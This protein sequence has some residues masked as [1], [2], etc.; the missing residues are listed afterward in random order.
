VVS[1]FGLSATL[2]LIS[3]VIL[4]QKKSIMNK[5]MVWFSVSQLK[6]KTAQFILTQA[7]IENYIIDKTD[8]A[9]AG[10]FGEIELYVSEDQENTAR[11]ILLDEEII[12]T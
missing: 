10:L 2:Y 5:S 3:V 1:F 6:I 8:S 4:V 12:S 9:H 7:G 11:K